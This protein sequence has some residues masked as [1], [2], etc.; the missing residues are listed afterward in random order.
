MLPL[1][2]VTNKQNDFI[3]LFL[4]V[5]QT[6]S[7]SLLGAYVCTHVPGEFVWQAGPL[8]QAVA[9]GRWLLFEDVD[10]APP[11]VLAALVPL[12]ESRE[13]QLPQRGQTLRAAPGF[14]LLASITSAPLGLGHGSSGGAYASSQ[15]VKDLLGG[16]F[17]Y[18]AVEPPPVDEIARILA[19]RFPDLASLAPLALDSLRLAQIAFSQCPWPS[20]ADPSGAGDLAAF[21]EASGVRPSDASLHTGRHLSIRDLIKWA[22]RLRT[23]HAAVLATTSTAVHAAIAQG[24]GSDAAALPM[25]LREACWVEAADVFC[26]H[27][28]N[29]D[30]RGRLLRAFCRLWALPPD[31]TTLNHE[32]QHRP[33]LQPT[34]ADLHVGR[35]TLHAVVSR[36]EKGL[37]GLAAAVGDHKPSTSSSSFARTAHTMRM[38]E[39]LAVALQQNEPALLV[40]ETGT[41]KTTLAQ[42]I[43]KNCGA[44]LT[45][46]NLSQQTDSSDL[47]GGFRPV[48]AKDSLLPLLPRFS[49][50]VRWTWPKGAND[51]F[52]A[53]ITQMAEKKRW[54]QLVKAMLGAAEKVEREW[55]SSLAS[56]SAPSESERAAGDKRKSP[57]ASAVPAAKKKKT[58]K[59]KG[60]T[61]EVLGEW[62]KFAAEVRVSQHVELRTQR[63]GWCL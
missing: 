56:T 22:T 46:L 51:E 49:T 24:R 29:E 19:G 6:D 7:K 37:Q 39:R 54:G 4:H 5:L 31:A 53:R 47:L 41:G 17:A 2:R 52:L 20:A 36:E 63:H 45:V 34:A 11:E 38:M 14:Q 3:L 48:D 60:I 62:N 27:V 12:M 26:A 8:T 43:A 33:Q 61:A 21:L 9:Q 15:G 10:M 44:K 25:T 23:V 57:D 32:S 55:T 16:L 35:A 18:V 40:G 1:L 50:L 58:S 28:P 59:T 30:A 42:E 13:L